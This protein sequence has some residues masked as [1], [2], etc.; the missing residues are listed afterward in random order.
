MSLEEILINELKN[1]KLIYYQTNKKLFQ[2]NLKIE[3][4]EIASP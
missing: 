1:L 4:T 2:N 3:V